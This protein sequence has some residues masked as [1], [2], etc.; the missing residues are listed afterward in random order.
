MSVHLALIDEHKPTGLLFWG[1]T[2]R[3][4]CCPQAPSRAPLAHTYQDRMR[5][6]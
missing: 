2:T 5:M 4:S 1:R 3:T 6:I